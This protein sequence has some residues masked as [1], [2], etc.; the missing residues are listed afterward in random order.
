MDATYPEP[1]RLEWARADAEFI[2]IDAEGIVGL[3][4]S[5]SKNGVPYSQTVWFTFDQLRALGIDSL[6][7]PISH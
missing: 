3:R 7:L 4:K 5:L 6:V 2:R 1:T